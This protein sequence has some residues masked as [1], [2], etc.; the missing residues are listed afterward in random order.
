MSLNLREFERLVQE[1]MKKMEPLPEVTRL[2]N[3][4][5]QLQE[6]LRTRSLRE[7]KKCA[8]ELLEQYEG[9]NDFGT[10]ETTR[11]MLKRCHFS[12]KDAEWILKIDMETLDE[13]ETYVKRSIAIRR[14]TKKLIEDSKKLDKQQ[15]NPWKF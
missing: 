15:E 8:E 6:I 11:K 12:K 14:V 10:I 3:L 13:L 4:Y 5:S 7:F 9:K 2:R 1:D